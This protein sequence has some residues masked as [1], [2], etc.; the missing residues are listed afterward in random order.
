MAKL[1]DGE[2][3]DQYYKCEAKKLVQRETIVMLKSELSDWTVL[4]SGISQG[5]I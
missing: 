2:E 3:G 1:I 5:L 4:T